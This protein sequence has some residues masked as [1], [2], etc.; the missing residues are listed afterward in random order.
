[1]SDRIQDYKNEVQ[2]QPHLTSMNLD[3]SPFVPCFGPWPQLRFTPTSP[4]NSEPK[5]EV[6]AYLWLWT[7]PQWLGGQGTINAF[8][9][10]ICP[11]NESVCLLLC[12]NAKLHEV[13]IA[14]PAGCCSGQLCREVQKTHS[15][16]C[17]LLLCTLHP[18][19][20][21]MASGP[22]FVIL[23][24]RKW[25]VEYLLIQSSFFMYHTCPFSCTVNIACRA[26]K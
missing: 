21:I 22:V 3:S 17:G 1:M 2:K 11:W 15:L 16:T 4:G 14:T 25:N 18:S 5:G 12:V 8:S 7:Y 9:K 23:Q 20:H 24:K 26:P 10:C 13:T 19:R 6:P